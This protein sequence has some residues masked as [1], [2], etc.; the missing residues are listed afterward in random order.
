MLFQHWAAQSGAGGNILSAAKDLG[1]DGIE[2]RGVSDELFVPKIFKNKEQEIKKELDR[3]T[4]EIP[5]LTS[6]CYLNEVGKRAQHISDGKQYID[7]ANEM[8]VPYIRLLGDYGPQQKQEVDPA[9]VLDALTELSEYAQGTQV[10]LLVE[11]NGYFAKSERLAKLLGDVKANNVGA[12]WD[13]QHPFRYNN[14]MPKDTMDNLKGLVRHMHIKDSH[15]VSGK[16]RNCMTGTG[17]APIV[18]AVNLLR[19]S[20]YD[21]YYSLE[22][23]K[24]WNLDLEEPGVAFASYVDYMRHL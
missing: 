13:I 17:D 14:E 15:L 6:A 9:A 8:N 3:L 12:L 20:G 11:T 16:V 23:T 22:W 1:Y 18:E 24:R 7:T 19:D 10:V 2:V 5:C 4:L 21:G